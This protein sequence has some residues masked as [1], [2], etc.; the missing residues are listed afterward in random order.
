MWILSLP[1]RVGQGTRSNAFLQAKEVARA[2]NQVISIRKR[3]RSLGVKSS[4]LHSEG[5]NPTSI[6]QVIQKRPGLWPVR[7]WPSWSRAAPQPVPRDSPDSNLLLGALR[8]VWEGRELAASGVSLMGATQLR[9]PPGALAS[10]R[11]FSAQKILLSLGPRKGDCIE[12]CLPPAS[13]SQ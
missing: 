6:I 7:V 10:G 3:T 11:L 4:R 12:L 5:L 8:L 9:I 13:E 2:Q 1:S